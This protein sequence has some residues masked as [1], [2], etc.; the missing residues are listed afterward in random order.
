MKKEK[1]LLI[2]IPTL[3]LLPFISCQSTDASA[4]S[5]DSQGV[6]EETKETLESEEVELTE[7]VEEVMEEEVTE[8]VEE[9]E[10]TKTIEDTGLCINPY[11]PV[12]PDTLWKYHV[13]NP[14]DAYEYT[15]SF[16]N[17]K[18][19]SFIEKIESE[20]FDADI[21][22]ICSSDGMVQSEY[23][24]LMI[25]EDNQ[26]M[27]FTTESFEGVTLPPPEKW[28]IG[29]KWDAE[30]KVLT[31]V[32]V[33]DERMSFSGNIVLKNE[34]V[35]IETV[36]V[37]A[38]T[39]PEAFK[40]DTDKN[41]NVS[42]DIAGNSMSFNAHTDISTWYSENTGLIKQISEAT[43]GITTVELLSVEEK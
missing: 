38:E 27:E 33:E 43:C 3:L 5:Q 30:Y 2:I 21:S 32:I 36:T 9:T 10:E 26:G 34:I 42:A 28:T 24:A 41:M 7:K 12:K 18:D 39:F 14:S 19:N 6:V 16:T 20:V 13:K 31:T 35:A 37:P 25:E 23:S 22:W 4:V 11:F 17:I 40:V 8:E 29:Y 1:I 15:S